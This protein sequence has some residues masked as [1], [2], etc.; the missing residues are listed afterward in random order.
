MRSADAPGRAPAMPSPAARPAFLFLNVLVV[1]TCGLVYELLAGAVA[2]YILGDSVTQF[3]LVIGLYLSAMGVGAFLSRFVERPSARFIEVELIVAFVGGISA[4]VLFAAFATTAAFSVLLYGIVVMVGMF[5][6]LELPLLMRILEGRLEFKEVVSRVLT[7]DYVGAL[8][9]SLLF[10]LLLVPALGLVRTS[11]VTGIANAGV[12]IWGSYLL[13]QELTPR[14]RR[15]ARAL[16]WGLIVFLALGV[17]QAGRLTSWSEEILYDDPVIFA[18]S[19]RYQRI[20]VTHKHGGFQLFLDG[21]L[22]FSSLDEYRYHEALVHP[23]IATL[24]RPPRSVLILG[25]GDGLA[26]RELL[27]HPSVAE[28]TLVDLDPAMT[29]LG[30]DFPLLVSLNGG[31]L[32]DPRVHVRNEDAFVFLRENQR[33]FDLVIVDFPDPNNFHL[34]KLYT[35]YFYRLLS[36]ALGEDG[37]AAVQSTSP[38]LSRRSFWCIVETMRAAEL[39][40]RPYQIQLPSFSQWGF[41]LAKN[42]PFAEPTTLPRVPLRF[43]S[44]DGMPSLFRFSPDI[45]EVPSEV[46][47]F[48]NQ[49]LVRTYEAEWR[50]LGK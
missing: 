41:V 2:S 46:N 11:L 26:V 19:S 24:P 14:E 38:L 30:R 31:S 5:V 7:F 10:P 8:A 16:G 48:D 9:A 45:A 33:R 22:Q 18:K 36:R 21:N 29:A 15:R 1:A 17:T 6:G 50:A 27:K 43:L 4:P 34:G 44:D 3:S 23:A 42:A 47:R 32:R 49:V 39:Q 20:V 40:V 37:V 25:G 12:G 13:A 35:R 28:V